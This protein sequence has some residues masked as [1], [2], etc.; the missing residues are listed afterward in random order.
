MYYIIMEKNSAISVAIGVGAVGTA[1]AYLGYSYYSKK[2]DTDNIVE[3]EDNTSFFDSLWNNSNT[4]QKETVE[5]E[6]KPVQQEMKVIKKDSGSEET[7]VE[8]SDS[9]MQ[10]ASGW[11]QFWKNSY[12]EQT[13]ELKRQ[14]SAEP[15]E[16]E[17]S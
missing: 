1:L 10:K 7:T 2:N 12:E 14:E 16:S 9:Q 4:E 8:T 3:Q 15:A 17:E 6:D 11:G 5:V 13:S